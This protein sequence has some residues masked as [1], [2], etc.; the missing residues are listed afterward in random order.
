M[1]ATSGGKKKKFNFATI[2]Q[3]AVDL[4]PQSTVPQTVMWA[5]TLQ[6]YGGPKM[7]EL[8]PKIERPFSEA[9]NSLRDAKNLSLIHI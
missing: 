8:H 6:T 4:V 3:L 7:K 9:F 1:K 2:M 5:D